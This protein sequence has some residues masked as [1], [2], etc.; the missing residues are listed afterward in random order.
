MPQAPLT[1]ATLG[2]L[3]DYLQY[4][5]SSDSGTHISAT[6]IAR[7]LELG[8]VQVRKDLSAVCGGGRPKVG[9]CKAELIA[10]LE[11]AL[12]HT[13]KSAA[14][15]VG[16]GRLGTALLGFDGF[17]APEIIAAFDT[18]VTGSVCGKPILPMTEFRSFCQL[19]DIRIGIITVP[20]EQA[21]NVCD[22][23]VANGIAAIWNFAP[24]KLKIPEKVILRQENLALSLAHLNLL[25]N[26]L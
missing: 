21:Q 14:V 17:N 12:R 25:A 11:D 19:H 5:R 23:M 16:A 4:L 6:T 24:V 15:I 2:R 26:Q 3:P 18:A 7:A 22:T 10:A 8:E 1:R 9:Y 20:V 13:K